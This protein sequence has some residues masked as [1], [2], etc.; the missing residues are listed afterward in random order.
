MGR[1]TT[2]NI[3]MGGII[4][5]ILS[6]ISGFGSSVTYASNLKSQINITALV[7]TDN[8]TSTES[9]TQEEE[10]EIEARE[11]AAELSQ[12]ESWDT[13]NKIYPS[14]KTLL[15]KMKLTDDITVIVLLKMNEDTTDGNSGDTITN[16]IYEATAPIDKA[17]SEIGKEIMRRDDAA[18]EEFVAEVG[19]E[20]RA[21]ELIDYYTGDTAA[22]NRYFEI[23]KKHGA[24]TEG[25]V[26]LELEIEKLRDIRNEKVNA[27]LE[28]Q[29]GAIQVE[30][31]QSIEALPDTEVIG[32]TL[33]TN[34]LDVQTK[35]ENIEALTQIPDVIRIYEN[36]PVFPTI[37]YPESYTWVTLHS[38]S[39]G[40]SGCTVNNPSFSWLSFKQTTKYQFILAKDAAMIQV[41]KE[42]QVP[43]PNYEYDGMLD[44]STYYFWRVMAIEPA[45]SDWSAIFS[46]QTEPAPI[47]VPQLAPSQSTAWSPTLIV[48]LIT[49]LAAA[50][51]ILTRF[52]VIRS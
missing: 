42:A 3:L 13:S 27:I 14:L 11:K 22:K 6:T 19:D 7:T 40:S 37:S 52:L 23:K 38:P 1:I 12:I 47:P 20:S 15:S 43:A 48:G 17:M 44:Y 35:V 8:V 41:I 10:E 29:F 36:A 49:V 2:V 21:K 9:A 45:P 26:I 5:L 39:D 30:A 4:F 50:I 31:R 51:G 46:F 28:Q 25:R 33:D 18:W 32:S 24:D 16:R 34:S